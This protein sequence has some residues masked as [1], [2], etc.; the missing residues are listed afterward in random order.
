MRENLPEEKLLKL[1]RTKKGEEQNP[2][3]QPTPKASEG[4]DLKYFFFLVNGVLILAALGLLGF[5]AYHLFFVVDEKPLVIPQEVAV[6]PPDELLEP[7]GIVVEKKPFEFYSEQFAKRDL[8]TRSLK[9]VAASASVDLTKRYKLVGIVLG[10]VPE[11]IIEDLTAK[12][13][14]FVHEGDRLDA[15]E[16]KSIKEGRIVFLQ[17]GLE[18][19]LKQ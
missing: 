17:E 13:T 7:Q 5:L 16:V 9:E 6:T 10:G 11:A 2:L 19:E 18:I 15:V 3:A 1:I 14:K 12:T 8:F 4:V